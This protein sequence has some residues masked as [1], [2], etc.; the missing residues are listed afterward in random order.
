M[1]L[2][3]DDALGPVDLGQAVDQLVGVGRRPEEPLLEH[4]G[5]DLGAAVL[6][7]SVA[8]LLVREHDLVLRAPLDRRLLPIGQPGS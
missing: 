3:R 4:P 8:D 2:H 7:V 1:A 6:A 5:L